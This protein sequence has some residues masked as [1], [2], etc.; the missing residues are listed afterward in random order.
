[1][2]AER[3]GRSLWGG[4]SGLRGEIEG[5]LSAEAGWTGAQ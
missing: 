2:R 3:Q 4:N 5:V 1:M